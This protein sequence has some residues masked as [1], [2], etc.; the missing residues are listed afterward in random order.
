MD[1]TKINKISSIISKIASPLAALFLLLTFLF[2]FNKD[3]GYF[4]NGFLSVSFM[5]T[6]A[7]G[8]FIPFLYFALFKREQIIKTPN[9]TEN[10]KNRIAL[11]GTAAIL[12]GT[13][14][15]LFNKADHES[16]TLL[17][18]AGLGFFGLYIMLTAISG[19]KSGFLKIACL[20]A[21]SLF[22]IGLNFSSLS[23]YDRSINSVENIL[24]SLFGIFFL[25]YILYEGKRIYTGEHSRWHYPAMLAALL[26]GFSLSSAYILAYMLNA[27]NEET[28]FY[29]MLTVLMA[30]LCIGF[31]AK[32]FAACAEARTHEEWEA[33]AE[34]ELEAEAEEL[35]EATEEVS[36]NAREEAPQDVS[37][38]KAAEA[39]EET[40][41]EIAEKTIED[42]VE[43]IVESAPDETPAEQ[44]ADEF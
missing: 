9:D 29:Q 33:L 41:E 24:G 18:G 26:S 8:I 30:T 31:E 20:F 40:A 12:V 37:D 44:T 15:I 32:R 27:V 6:C 38:E 17:M 1:F 4:E 43:D 2:D 14:N 28:R 23:N 22:S 39:T 3:S 16:I 35:D 13:F 7:A 36:E 5:V 21:S 10:D 19:Y 11:F 25:I 42:A 34:A